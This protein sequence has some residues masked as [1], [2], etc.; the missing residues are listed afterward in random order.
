[1]SSNEYCT[2]NRTC[3]MQFGTPADVGNRSAAPASSRSRRLRGG[4]S[5]GC[6]NCVI[7]EGMLEAE[8]RA[9]RNSCK[10]CHKAR[11]Q[12]LDMGTVLYKIAQSL[13]Q[14][15]DQIRSI[16]GLVDAATDVNVGKSY[17]PEIIRID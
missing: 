11:E 2:P 7:L 5:K 6:Q 9:R 12:C 3:P 15:T 8:R 13:Q 14:A 4:T 1:M 16:E 17:V 10:N